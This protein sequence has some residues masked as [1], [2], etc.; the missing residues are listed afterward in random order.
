[1]S[2]S[3]IW[4]RRNA[5]HDVRVA[6]ITQDLAD[7]GQSLFSPPHEKIEVEAAEVTSQ[8]KT[9]F[10]YSPSSMV[11]QLFKG[12]EGFRL[13]TE[14]AL[15]EHLSIYHPPR[16]SPESNEEEQRISRCY[17][18]SFFL[19]EPAYG[20]SHLPVTQD[21]M[22]S[23]LTALD[24]FPNIY[25]Y[26]KAF[27]RKTFA[28]DEGFAGFDS[29]ITLDNVGA[30]AS[31]ECC[32]L[33]KYVERRRRVMTGT[34]P[35]SI[36]HALIYQKISHESK[37]ASHI[38]IRLPERVKQELR[39]HTTPNGTGS[40]AFIEDWVHLHSTCFS[41]IDDDLREYIN[42]LDEEVT[43]VFEHVIMP[44]L[45]SAELSENDWAQRSI[46][47][48]STLQY[49]CEQ[50]K[51]LIDIIG[52]NVDMMKCFQKDV[53]SLVT[54]D[55]WAP[56][57]PGSPEVV[58]AL[59]DKIQQEHNFILKNASAVLER[60][61]TT[62]EQV[63]VAASLRVRDASRR[64]V[65]LANQRALATTNWWTSLVEQHMG[66]IMTALVLLLLLGSLVA[67]FFTMELQEGDN[68]QIFAVLAIALVWGAI[69][70][71]GGFGI[72]QGEKGRVN[73]IGNQNC[74]KLK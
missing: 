14:G 47:D 22:L 54:L 66:R 37:R 49:L 15:R 12:I 26:L 73:G 24:V 63:R 51:R 72:A 70:V 60:A 53:N 9:P 7:N 11:T 35:W 64:Y 30:W 38:L 1:M 31:F 58:S 52:L 62:S 45:N 10:L 50:A 41:S 5:S 69:L 65:E 16:L 27:G 42:F 36:R 19:L 13:E 4:P 46:D 33:L 2:A 68:L 6:S 25:R 67:R 29:V 17:E 3:I 43:K 40:V 48:F 61:R 56:A 44:S 20:W 8:G 39:D 74:R 32:Y 34:N 18:S 28:R 21:G 59:L 55:T 71:Y 57:R 23:L